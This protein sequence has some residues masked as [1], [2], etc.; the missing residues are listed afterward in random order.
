MWFEWEGRYKFDYEQ[1]IVHNP[2]PYN[3]I[4]NKGLLSFWTLSVF[5]NSKE[6]SFRNWIHFQLHVKMWEAPIVLVPLQNSAFGYL[7]K[8]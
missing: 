8:Q 5:L 7:C 3:A 6:E 4:H 1:Q 2:F